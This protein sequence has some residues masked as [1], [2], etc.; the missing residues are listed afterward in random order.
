MDEHET[1]LPWSRIRFIAFDIDGTLT[2]GTTTWLGTDVGWSQTYSTRDGEALLRLRRGGLTVVPVSRNRTA[3]ARERMQM[4][5]MPLDWL[6]VS[7]KVGAFEAALARYRSKPEEALHVGDGPDDVPLVEAAAIGCAVADG[8]LDVRAAA[9]LVLTSR[10]GE[11]VIEEIE[12]R[13]SGRWEP[14]R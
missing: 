9:D 7:D 11:R 6:G 13:L 5:G 10:G 3:V 4:L 2:D 1:R 14:A 8:H 12:L